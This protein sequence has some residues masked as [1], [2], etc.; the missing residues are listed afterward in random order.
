L[1]AQASTLPK[2]LELGPLGLRVMAALFDAFVGILIWYPFFHFWGYYNEAEHQYQ[3]SG[4]PALAM[5]FATA[6][7]W[8]LTEWIFGATIGKL[9]CD[10]RVVS[11]TG[12]KCSFGQSVKRNLV[13][14]IDFF[15]FYLTGFLAAKFSPI[16]QRLGDQWA[17][18]IVVKKVPKPESDITSEAEQH[19]TQYPS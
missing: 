11:L 3:V 10:L 18:T 4:L 9:I 12:A 17:K 13:R 15:P 2:G 7:Y 19:T 14:T 6:A 5:F 8:I 16:R 1:A